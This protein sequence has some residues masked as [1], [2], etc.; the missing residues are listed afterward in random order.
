[1][2]EWEIHSPQTLRDELND[3]N[4]DEEIDYGQQLC[5]DILP[6]ECP[7]GGVGFS[8]LYVKTYPLAKRHCYS[9]IHII[10]SRRR[11]RDVLMLFSRRYF[12]TLFIYPFL[13]MTTTM[14]NANK[15]DHA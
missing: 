2:R 5:N 1:M 12:S 8:F 10:D 7:E 15:T 9:R 6:T 14:K 4:S 3:A 11:E 13:H